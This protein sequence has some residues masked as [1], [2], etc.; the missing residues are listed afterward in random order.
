MLEV[1]GNYLEKLLFEQTIFVLCFF[2][3]YTDKKVQ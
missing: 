2:V 1:N 3:V